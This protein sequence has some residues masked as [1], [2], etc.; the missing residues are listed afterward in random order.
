MRTLLILVFTVVELLSVF[1]SISKK[2]QGKEKIRCNSI[3]PG[4]IWLDTE[5]KPI[6]AHGFF[7]FL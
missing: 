1:S 4:Q 2:V 6:Q 5:G 7:C 3:L